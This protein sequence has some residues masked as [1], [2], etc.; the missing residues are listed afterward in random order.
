MV[1]GR[2]EVVIPL[3]ELEWSS[4]ATPRLTDLTRWFT[5]LSSFRPDELGAAGAS[6]SAVIDPFAIVLHLVG[7]N[8]AIEFTGA[9]DGPAFRAAVIDRGGVDVVVTTGIDVRRSKVG[10][11]DAVARSGGAVGGRVSAYG[12]ESLD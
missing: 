11:I 2:A 9:H 4:G 6:V 7:P 3:E 10:E 12:V 8:D 5:K 1:D